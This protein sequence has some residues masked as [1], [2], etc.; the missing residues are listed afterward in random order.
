MNRFEVTGHEPSFLP[1][2]NWKLVWADEF[3]GTELDTTKW[4]FRLNF[5]G[6]PFD[7]YTDQ[8]IVLDGNSHVELHRT[9]RNGC[10]VSPQLQTGSNSF[11]IP[12][13]NA[14]DDWGHDKIWQMRPFEPP[15]FVHRYGYYECRCKFQKDPETMWSAFWLQ[16]P[17]IGARY[18]PEWCGVE[19]DIMECFQPGIIKSGN[20]MGGYGEQGRSD[21]RVRNAL[22]ETPDGWHYF[23]LDWQPDGYVFYWDGH[24]V[25][26][27]NKHVSHVPQFILLTTEVQGY[28]KAGQQQAAL[29][30]NPDA[31]K[32]FPQTVKGEF[33]DDAFIVDFV[34]VF[35]RVD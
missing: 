35:D 34:R 12:R 7:A 15:K 18:E 13:L 6:K 20:I 22:K 4:G 23:G 3:D 30:E 29:K 19:A 5:W 26:R 2:G 16:S 31:W 32:E 8:G 10:Y 28:R 24:E 1:D 21:G 27:C 9:E 11:D 17:T 14:K 25:S 33:V